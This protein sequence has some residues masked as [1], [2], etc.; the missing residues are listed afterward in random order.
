M[1]SILEPTSDDDEESIS[2][3]EFIK[4]SFNDRYCWLLPSPGKLFL[5]IAQS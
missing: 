3:Y 1:E 4:N 2:Q 5:L